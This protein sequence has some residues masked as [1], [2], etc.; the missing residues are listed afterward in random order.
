M[1]NQI[2][3]FTNQLFGNVRSMLDDNGNPWFLGLDVATCLGYS[4]TR[5][6]LIKHVDEEDKA[7]VAF[8]DASSIQSRNMIFINESGLYSLIFG[9]KLP[10]A[11]QFKHWVTAEVLPTMRKIGF[12]RSMQVLQEENM[13]LKG[14]VE[15]YQNS[16]LASNI[17]RVEVIEMRNQII[18][19]LYNIPIGTPITQEMKQYLIQYDP[20]WEG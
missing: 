1:E 3:L 18:D 5:D 4:N 12:S 17:D 9:S 14:M 13:K 7:T 10:A 20:N 8:R 6:A 19:K 11:K 2:Q 16:N 15:G